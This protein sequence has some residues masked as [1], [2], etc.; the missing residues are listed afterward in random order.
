MAFNAQNLRNAAKNRLNNRP[1]ASYEGLIMENNRKLG[2]KDYDIFLSHRKLDED[3]IYGIMLNLESYGYKVYVDWIEDAQMSREDVNKQT[4]EWLRERL[5]QSRSLMYV[6]TENSLGSKWMPW[7]LGYMD[8]HKPQKSTILPI[9][10]ANCKNQEYLNLYPPTVE[11][12]NSLFVLEENGNKI[13]FKKWLER[14][15]KNRRRNILIDEFIAP[16]RRYPGMP[17]EIF[18]KM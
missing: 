14:G 13:E 17:P 16:R 6:H 7:E 1:N 18:M 12:V 9:D 3:L 15:A 8:G 10:N 5:N 11:E 2:Q 4:A